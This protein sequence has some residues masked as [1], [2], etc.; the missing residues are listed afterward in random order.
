MA[1]ALPGW[2]RQQHPFER[3]GQIPHSLGL[4]WFVLA[5]LVSASVFIPLERRYARDPE[6]VV[7][8]HVNVRIDGGWLNYLLVLPRYHWHHAR[9]P[10]Y[11]YES[12]AS[13]HEACPLMSGRA[14]C[15]G[16][17]RIQRQYGVRSWAD[18]RSDS[19]RGRLWRR[20]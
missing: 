20:G 13:G 16:V 6:Q 8:A 18:Q 15:R 19:R 4:D 9:H 14:N 11:I 10:D 1:T 3:I 2:R 17:A 12:C 5:L 7:L